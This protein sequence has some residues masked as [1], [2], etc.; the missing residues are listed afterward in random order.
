MF[1][2]G[3]PGVPSGLLGKEGGLQA[4]PRNSLLH[5]IKEV[6]QREET[7]ALTEDD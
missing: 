1:A 7:A 6:G 2:R 5:G 3:T 4:R